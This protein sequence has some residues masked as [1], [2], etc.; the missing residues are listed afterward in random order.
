M[1]NKRTPHCAEHV[2]WIVEPWGVTLIHA[3]HG[4]SCQLPYPEAA[5]WDLLTRC[6]PEETI[7]SM[8]EL[9]AG[10]GPHEAEALVRSRLDAWAEEGWLETGGPK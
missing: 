7:R 8:L 9:I 4:R 5:I 3:P 6:R 1:A 10:I 2:V